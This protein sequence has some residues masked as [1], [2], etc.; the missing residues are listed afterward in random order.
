MCYVENSVS[1]YTEC[2][3]LDWID[4]LD[5]TEDKKIDSLRSGS[6]KIEAYAD[7]IFEQ[8]W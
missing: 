2:F 7:L 4:K 3:P 1:E 8:L 6:D 5:W